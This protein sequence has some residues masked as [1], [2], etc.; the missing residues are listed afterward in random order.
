MRETGSAKLRP[1]LRPLILRPLWRPW[2][3]FYQCFSIRK[4]KHLDWQIQLSSTYHHFSWLQTTAAFSMARA[5]PLSSKRHKHVVPRLSENFL[6][7]P[8]SNRLI[9][10]FCRTSEMWKQTEPSTVLIRSSAPWLTL[11][12]MDHI[13]VIESYPKLPSRRFSIATF[14]CQRVLVFKGNLHSSHDPKWTKVIWRILELNNYP[15]ETYH[16]RPKTR[17]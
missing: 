17:R 7:K 15:S 13:S 16:F 14:D 4:Y 10:R 12:A 11:E 9:N 8:G 2:Y 5:M 3:K 6:S 1:L